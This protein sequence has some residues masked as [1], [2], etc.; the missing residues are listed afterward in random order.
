MEIAGRKGV[1]YMRELDA[2]LSPIY[3]PDPL[4]FAAW[5][6]AIRIERSPQ[7]KEEENTTP[8]SPAPAPAA[9][10]ASATS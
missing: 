1:A 3:E 6:T 7:P 10:V 9:V 8:A 5:K 2:I 4:V